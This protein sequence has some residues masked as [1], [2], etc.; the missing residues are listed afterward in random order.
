M[1]ARGFS[2]PG[3]RR[4]PFRGR[5]PPRGLAMSFYFP[6]RQECAHHTIFP[7]VTIQTCAASKMMLSLAEL[8]AHAVVEEH[9]HPHEQVGMV[10][11]GKAVFT[12]GGEQKTLQS[13]DMYRIPG[14]VRH[15]VIALDQPVK[16][17][18]IFYPIRE[19]YL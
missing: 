1:A 16:A 7:G 11:E 15:K 9:S 2:I 4:L 12:I 17:L 3:A 8:Q 10:L 13:G 6:T 18:D 19:T 14:H 5:F